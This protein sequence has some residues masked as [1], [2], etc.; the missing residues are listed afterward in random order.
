M[1]NARMLV[2]VLVYF[3]FLLQAHE[4]VGEMDENL[5]QLQHLVIFLICLISVPGV[6]L[7]LSGIRNRKAM[8]NRVKEKR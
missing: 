5:H 2:T 7:K 1:N 3:P 4:V 8:K 6:L